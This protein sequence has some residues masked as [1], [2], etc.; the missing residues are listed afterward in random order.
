MNEKPQNII[1]ILILKVIQLSE[2]TTGKIII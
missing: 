1:L 2:E